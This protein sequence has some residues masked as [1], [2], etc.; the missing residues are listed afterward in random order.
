MAQADWLTGGD[1]RAL[2]VERIY[3]VTADLVSRAGFDAVSIDDVA[4]R[5][6]CSRAT[7]YRYVGGKS[8]LRTGVL[9]RSS[10]RIAE[11]IQREIGELQGSERV[12]AA[13]TESIRAVRAD[14][15]A[16]KFLAEAAPDEIRRFLAGSPQLAQ[17]ATVLTGLD[18]AQ[19]LAAQWT[20]RVV[21]SLLIWPADSPATERQLIEQFVAPAFASGER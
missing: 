5:A 10:A 7:V 15:V 16:S 12:V 18:T 13:I 21:L 14:A 6:G 17:T 11:A 4:E 2:A 9:A 1:R 20:V 3:S 19:P 8:G